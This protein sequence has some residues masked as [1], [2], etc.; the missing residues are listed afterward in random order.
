MNSTKVPAKLET[1]RALLAKAEDPRTPEA[2]AELARRR[3]FEMMAKYGVEQAMLNDAN[4][5]SDAP[6]D[7]QI[8]LDN[9]WAM[10]RVRL[11][12][13]IAVALGCQLIHLGRDG[14]G[15]ARR[16]H[17][18]GYASDLERVELL[19]TS[20]LLQMNGGLNAQTVP[21]RSGARA[22]RR[23]WLLGFISRVGDR[24]EEAERG[25]CEQASAETTATGRSAALVLADRKSVVERSYRQ[26]YPRA[27]SGGRTTMTGNG[28]G[29]GWSAG[30][31]ADIGGKRIGRTGAGAIAA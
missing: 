20:L 11:I 15:P 18:F 30:S 26:A 7:R 6:A 4:P 31:R 5:A 14:D 27:R 29:A 1:I 24:I 21:V 13:R 8:V 17:I 2:E 10:E 9:P 22:W 3:A 28:Y 16:V 12:N 25:A 23:S 19:Y